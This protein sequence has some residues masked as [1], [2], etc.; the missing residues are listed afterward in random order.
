MNSLCS[1]SRPTHFRSFTAV[2]T[3]LYR[4]CIWTSPLSCTKCAQP[5]PVSTVFGQD[6]CAFRCSHN[7][8][9]KPNSSVFRMAMVP[10]YL[11]YTI[12]CHLMPESKRRLYTLITRD[13]TKVASCTTVPAQVNSLPGAVTHCTL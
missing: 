12:L 6:L 9:G 1:V 2:Q 5:E 8:V 11:G 4:C 7:L 13:I 3:E 10:L